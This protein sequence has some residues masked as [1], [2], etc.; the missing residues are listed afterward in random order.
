MVTPTISECPSVA[1]TIGSPGGGAKQELPELSCFLVILL[2]LDDCQRRG[3]TAR[4]ATPLP[5]DGS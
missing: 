5:H 3:S 4:E 2:E 1:T